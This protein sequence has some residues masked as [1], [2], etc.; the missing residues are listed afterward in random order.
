MTGRRKTES[1]TC[2]SYD[3]M[4]RFWTANEDGWVLEYELFILMAK[5]DNGSL[6]DC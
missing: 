5:V 6:E 3:G 2:V 1:V 4:N